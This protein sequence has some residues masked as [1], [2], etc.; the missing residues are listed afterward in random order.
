MTLHFSGG[1]GWGWRCIHWGECEQLVQNDLVLEGWL[2]V[3]SSEVVLRVV[4]IDMFFEVCVGRLLLGVVDELL[5]LRSEETSS[6][7]NKFS[8]L[9]L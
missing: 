2:L 3:G 1:G 6:A 5:V 8:T 9:T 4:D 7:S